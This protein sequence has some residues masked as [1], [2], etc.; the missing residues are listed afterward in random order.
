[1]LHAIFPA[2]RLSR[3]PLPERAGVQAAFE[4]LRAADELHAVGVPVLGTRNGI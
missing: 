3:D 2:G 1:M 4:L